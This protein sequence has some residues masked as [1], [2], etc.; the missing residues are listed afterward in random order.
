MRQASKVLKTLEAF[1]ML[2]SFAADL[3]LALRI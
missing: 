3:R 1:F 2:A